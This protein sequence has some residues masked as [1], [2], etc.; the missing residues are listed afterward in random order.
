MKRKQSAHADE[1]TLAPRRDNMQQ[2]ECFDSA[3][4]WLPPELWVIV[5][6]FLPPCMLRVCCFVCNDW[7]ATLRWRIANAEDTTH[8]IPNHADLS[9]HL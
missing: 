5:L 6:D 4:P 2:E 9:F 7:Y 1:E 3:A 8:P